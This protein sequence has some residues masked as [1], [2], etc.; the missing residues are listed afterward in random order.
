MT[1]EAY[2]RDQRFEPL[3]MGVRFPDGTGTWVP[4]ER[5]REFFASYDLSKFAVLAHHAHFD[6]L[7]L[8]HHLGQRPAF[9]FDTLSMARLILGNHVP[10]GLESL[11][12]H[13]DLPAK[14]VPYSMFDGK[15][16]A[17][18]YESEREALGQGSMH[19]CNLTWEI[20]TKLAQGF[21]PREYKVI[22]T[23]VR[24]FTE[25]KLEADLT[26]LS[27]I[28][29]E[30]IHKKHVLLNEL[31]VSEEDLQSSAKF[32][33][34]LQNEGV[35]VEYKGGKNGP[36][37]AIA[38]TDD[39]MKGLV[40]DE[41]DR[42]ATLAQARLE[43]RSTI[44]QTRAGRLAN[45]GSRGA[46]CVY[47]KPYGAHTT[48]VSGADALNFTNFPG[49]H[50]SRLRSAVVAPRGYLIATVDSAQGECRILN[51]LAGQTDILE[52][53]RAKRDI[54]SENAS[55]FYGH[56]VNKQEHPK[57]RHLGKVQELMLGFGAGAERFQATCRAGALGGPPILL[58]DVEAESAVAQYRNDHPFVVNYWK[59]AG[60]MLARIAGGEPLAWGPF[61][62]ETG[63]VTLEGVSLVYNDMRFNADDYEGWSYRSRSGR[64]RIWGS[65]LVENLVQFAHRMAVWEQIQTIERE[66]KLPLVL[67]SYDDASFLIPDD[68][69]AEQTLAWLCEKFRKAPAWLA[70]CPFD[71]DGVIGRT[72]DK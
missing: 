57:Q 33:E 64:A 60:R 3:L 24:M 10:A 68:Q 65:K 53:F 37:P 18:L 69:W 26:L 48:R 43:V 59:T 27:E 20:F 46:L 17:N 39:F 7:I 44:A 30:E 11:A 55:R 12:K 15:V 61:V 5:L 29:T 71:S 2:V 32:V 22:D 8:S 66:S 19:D 54:Y 28:T 23:L 62:V 1:T 38:K 14:T 36:I 42:V 50:R 25:P 9:W 34:L 52:A 31:G 35:E 63:K 67:H 21:P 40:D 70:D 51:T 49:G 58:T 4:Q 56:P 16:W 6:G 45:M 13:F 47:L 41:N 72:Y